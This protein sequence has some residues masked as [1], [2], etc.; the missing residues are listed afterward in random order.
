MSLVL[1]D[2]SVW[3]D[4]FNGKDN[5]QVKQL[6]ELLNGKAICVCPTIIQEILQGISDLKSFDTIKEHL[7]RQIVLV[8]EPVEAAIQAAKIY[9]LLRKAGIT[10]RQS[11]DC[12]IAYH[13]LHYEASI[14]HRDRDYSNMADRIGLRIA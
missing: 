9:Q 11:N 14:L 8:C 5:A 12:L 7:L 1:V 6:S 10:I 2:T 13:A 4:F 3:I